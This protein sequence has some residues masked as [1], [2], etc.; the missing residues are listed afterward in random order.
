MTWPFFATITVTAYVHMLATTILAIMCRLNFG[1]GLAHYCEFL[2]SY[3]HIL[4]SLTSSPYTVRVTDALDGVDFTPVYF[5]KGFENEKDPE[6]GG[7]A[8][9][10]NKS[11]GI[12]GSGGP[13][14]ISILRLPI[15]AAT[16]TQKKPPRGVS[17]YSD[18]GVSPIM[19]SSSPPL[20]S[21]LGGAP[22]AEVQA[23]S[24]AAS[25]T[26]KTQR[27]S[28]APKKSE[29]MK[30]AGNVVNEPVP[31]LPV[32]TFAS[33]T[34]EPAPVPSPTLDAAAV[35]SA[36]ISAPPP[37]VIRPA[38]PRIQTSSG[39]EYSASVNSSPTST[40]S[41]RYSPLNTSMSSQALPARTGVRGQ[42]LPANP[43]T[44]SAAKGI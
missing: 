44:R 23:R 11:Q 12:N 26:S 43:R 34:T 13:P 35:G 29:S 6:K 22:S 15:T 25:S 14:L 20:V 36:Q 27:L 24:K 1:K 37:A 33:P 41:G 28:K 40:I 18:R 39:M 2:H 16:V 38:A 8:N 4:A 31:A 9:E 10:D 19:I 7:L 3:S 21:D 30:N 42:G 32:P 5:T 17:I